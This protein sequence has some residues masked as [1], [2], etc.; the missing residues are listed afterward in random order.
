MIGIARRQR[1]VGIAFLVAGTL[2]TG[3]STTGARAQTEQNRFGPWYRDGID[4]RWYFDVVLGVESEPDYAGSDDSE[5]EPSID[6]RAIWT[7]RRGNRYFLRLGELGAVFFPARQWALEVFLEYEESREVDE[8]P[9]L[10]G[11]TEL[12]DTIEGQLTVYRRFG[13]S[14]YVAATL[15]PDLLGRG[16]G[17][18]Y[19]VGA[20]YDWSNDSGRFFLNPRIDVSWGDREHL[21]AEFGVTEE[22]ALA[23]GLDVHAP[24]GGLKSATLG[25]LSHVTLTRRMDLVGSLEIETYFGDAADSPLLRDEGTDVTLEATIGLLWRF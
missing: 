8:N 7:D 21:E 6:V 2:A 16:K 14:T 10:R 9:A 15:Q 11:A 22:H 12:D 5:L 19:F 24:G 18:V 20:G 4:D 25:L 3:M 13:R 23:A 17:F 1:I